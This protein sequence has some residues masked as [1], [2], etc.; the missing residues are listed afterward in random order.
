MD[1]RIKYAILAI[2]LVQIFMIIGLLVLPP[3][4]QALPG[5]IRVR[6][7]RIPLG[8]RLLDIGV[9][10]MPTALPVPSGAIARAQITIPTL[11]AAT[12]TP[13]TTP[14]APVARF[15]V[16]TVKEIGS[17]VEPTPM[18]TSTAAP[19]FTPTPMPLPEQARIEGM[20]IIAQ[21][22][23]NCGPANR[24]IDEIHTALAPG[25]ARSRDSGWGAT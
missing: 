11:T 10:P 8:E 1:K 12:P 6:L 4:A 2:A 18:A 25:L 13:G 17:T 9:T 23:N 21:G 3:I 14:T 16:A 7:A 24:R 15:K 22:F 20:K 19:T 5:E